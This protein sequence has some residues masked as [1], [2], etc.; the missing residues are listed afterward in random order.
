[1]AL[2]RTILLKLAEKTS[3]DKDIQAFLSD[4]FQFE[5]VPRGWYEKKYNELLEKYCMEEVEP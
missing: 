3:E 5:S 4:I 1:M 2:N